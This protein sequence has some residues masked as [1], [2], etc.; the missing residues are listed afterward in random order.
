VREL[1]DGAQVETERAEL[2]FSVASAEDYMQRFESRHPAGMLF[3]EVL[4]GAGGY[5]ETRA[6]AKAALGDV[7]SITSSYLIHTISS[8]RS[9]A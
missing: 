7:R 5:E 9:A 4:T 6:Q 3:R 8:P 1:F 2:T